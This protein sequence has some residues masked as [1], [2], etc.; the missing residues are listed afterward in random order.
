MSKQ[1]LFDSQQMPCCEDVGSSGDEDQPQKTQSPDSKHVRYAE[2]D[3]RYIYE[4]LK[5]NYQHAGDR[6]YDIGRV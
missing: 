2:E 3:Q 5:K 1:N 4:G 6:L